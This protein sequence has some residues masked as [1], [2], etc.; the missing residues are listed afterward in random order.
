[1]DNIE[2]IEI[3]ISARPGAAIG[4]CLKEA[5]ELASK[6]WRNVRLTHNGKDYMVKPNDLLA[7]VEEVN[8]LNRSMSHNM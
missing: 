2:V 6:E 1:M 7:S 5:I 8:I 3:R 4:N